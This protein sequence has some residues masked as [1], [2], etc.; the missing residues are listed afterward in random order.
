MTPA[1]RFDKKWVTM[2]VLILLLASVISCA[3][4]EEAQLR[5]QERLKRKL[6]GYTTPPGMPSG[7]VPSAW[8]TCPVVYV[9][10]FE[11]E[12]GQFIGVQRKTGRDQLLG[13]MVRAVSRGGTP[14]RVFVQKVRRIGD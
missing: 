6:E 1:S 7:T 9:T 3:A 4:L 8:S 13:D 5:R 11:R 10:R 14:L 2:P 12:S